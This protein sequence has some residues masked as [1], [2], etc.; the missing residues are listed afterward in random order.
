MRVGWPEMG[1]EIGVETWSHGV[2]RA[3][4]KGLDWVLSMVTSCRRALCRGS[5][6]SDLSFDESPLV[7]VCSAD[8]GGP[9]G[10]WKKTVWVQADGGVC[11][12]ELGFKN[13]DGRAGRTCRGD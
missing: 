8:C 11:G 2:L 6:E 5:I 7:V 12:R 1:L 9:V 4:P 13:C 3:T 10:E